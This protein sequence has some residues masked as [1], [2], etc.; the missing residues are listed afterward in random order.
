MR[1]THECEEKYLEMLKKVDKSTLKQYVEQEVMKI[2][3]EL[4]PEAVLRATL[5]MFDEDED[6]E[7]DD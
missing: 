7:D 2:E 1:T 5:A 4:T 3:K 6:N